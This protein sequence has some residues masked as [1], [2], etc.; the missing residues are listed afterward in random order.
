M[1]FISLLLTLCLYPSL[2]VSSMSQ[3]GRTTTKT[4]LVR[5]LW[6]WI[7]CLENDEWE[8]E[9]R[10]LLRSDSFEMIQWWYMLNT[11]QLQ[12]SEQIP[13]EINSIVPACRGGSRGA[14]WWLPGR[15][16]KFSHW[17]PVSISVSGKHSFPLHISKDIWWEKRYDS[18]LTNDTGSTTKEF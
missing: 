15:Q 4:T 7:R 6:V 1:P 5:R 11:F 2:Q 17:I 18:K 13:L 3:Y 12:I 8:Y 16:I 9:K 10:I 14:W